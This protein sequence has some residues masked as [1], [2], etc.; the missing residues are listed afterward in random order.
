MPA[1]KHNRGRA[2]TKFS[3]EL[4]A[5]I[6]DHVSRG[7]SLREV[8]KDQGMPTPSTVYRWIREDEELFSQWQ[9]VKILRSHAL[10]D[11]A[12]DLAK[13][14]VYRGLDGVSMEGGRM[15]TMNQIRA[16]QVAVETLKDAAS[17]LNPTDYG[18]RKV[19]DVVVPIQIVTNMNMGQDGKPTTESG[20]S[21]YEIE[22]TPQVINDPG[23]LPPN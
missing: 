16:V 9:A 13:T 11:E 5:K 7:K 6:F 14:L 23:Q 19:G 8:C 20:T 18:Q 21:I 1:I 15:A 10:F 22:V 4:V 12:V 2:V 3:P 17:K